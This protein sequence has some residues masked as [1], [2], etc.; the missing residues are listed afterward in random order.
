M[1]PLDVSTTDF[2]SSQQYREAFAAIRDQIT[3]N[4]L[5]LLQRHYHAPGRTIT[6]RRLAECVGYANYG[7]VNA[8]YGALAK[9]LCD[10]L[11]VRF[12]EEYWV[13][14]VAMFA[15]DPDVEGGELQWVMR[16]Q[17]AHALAALGWVW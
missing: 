16:P 10:A 1:R 17:V 14:I 2:P 7:G 3:V 4:Q 12:E 5:L 15:R 9:H 8:Q 6:A 13:T 11:Q